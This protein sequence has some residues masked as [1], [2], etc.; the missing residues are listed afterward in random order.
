MSRI[1][2]GKSSAC[3]TTAT[4]C[5]SRSR[6]RTSRLPRFSSATARPTSSSA[7]CRRCWPRCWGRGA[8]S[9][10]RTTARNN[11]ESRALDQSPILF[12][13]KDIAL[14]RFAVTARLTK[15]YSICPFDL[16]KTFRD[17]SVP[18]KQALRALE[19]IRRVD[20]SARWAN[21]L[22]PLLLSEHHLRRECAP[23]D[24]IPKPLCELRLGSSQCCF[25]HLDAALHCRHICLRRQLSPNPIE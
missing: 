1:W 18:M 13:K 9:R 15:S 20:V 23:A 24:A 6:R 19:R 22:S 21:I 8:P 12:G 25:S 4:S 3:T 2:K 11:F 14:N 5:A 7:A 17:H 10:E 16:I